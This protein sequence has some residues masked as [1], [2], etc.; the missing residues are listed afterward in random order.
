VTPAAS[1]KLAKLVRLL[2]SDKDGEVLAAASAI[3]RTLAAEGSDIHALAD[4]LCRPQP[5]RKEE[6]RR[7]P[8]PPREDDWHGMAC[9]CQ[10]RSERLSEREQ[11]FIDDMVEWTAFREPT[12]RQQAWL[13]SIYRRVLAEAPNIQRRPRQP[14][15]GARAAHGRAAV[16]NLEV[17]AAPQEVRGARPRRER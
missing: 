1:D 7:Q 2:S 3:K 12:E 11:G 6:P 8:P 15:G 17:G 10:E 13:L 16:G 5:Q 9:E 14:A 4:A